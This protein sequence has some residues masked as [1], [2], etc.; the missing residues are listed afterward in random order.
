MSEDKKIAKSVDKTIMS[1]IA[2]FVNKSFKFP[3]KDM[4]EQCW[5]TVSKTL[6]RHKELDFANLNTYLDREKYWQDRIFNKIE[7][8]SNPIQCP[9]CGWG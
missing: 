4:Q 9:R 2:A 3:N 1:I 8:S 6:E 7:I 5:Y